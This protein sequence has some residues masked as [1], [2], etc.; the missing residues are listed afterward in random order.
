MFLIVKSKITLSTFQPGFYIFKGKLS[1]L[2]K[3]PIGNILDA[4]SM[5]IIIKTKSNEM[6]KIISEILTVDEIILT[7]ITIGEVIGNKDIPTTI[8]EEEFVTMGEIMTRGIIKKIIK[9]HAS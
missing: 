8:G 6:D 4:I 1:P 7:N 5:D 9:G 2:I 3:I